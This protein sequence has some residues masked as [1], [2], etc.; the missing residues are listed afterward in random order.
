MP[1]NA[2]LIVDVQNDFCPGGNLAVSGGDEVVP[3]INS[4]AGKFPLAVATKDWHPAGHISLLSSHPGRQAMETV[5]I[6]GIEQTIWPDHC[7]QNTEGARLHPGLD[8]SGV[9]CILHKGYKSGLD[10]YSAFFENDHSTPTG[11]SFYLRGLGVRD[12]YVS[13]LAEDVCVFATAM[14]AEKLGFAVY[15]VADAVRGVDIPEGSADHAR[16]RM[17]ERGVLYISVGDIPA[18]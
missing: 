6:N 9:H 12:V 17:K 7:V 18:S 15:V 5:E 13:G 11:L 1:N 16:K 10:S 2:L 3:V 8:L 4:I 14:D